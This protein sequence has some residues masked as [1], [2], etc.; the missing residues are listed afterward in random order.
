MALPRFSFS[1]V[2]QARFFTPQ[3]GGAGRFRRASGIG[4][5]R[6]DHDEN[7]NETTHLQYQTWKRGPWVGIQLAL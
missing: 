6:I 1:P 5:F 3:I 2:W 7:F 4:A